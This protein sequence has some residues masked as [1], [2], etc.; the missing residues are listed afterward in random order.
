MYKYYFHRSLLTIALLIAPTLTHAGVQIN[1]IAWMGG[2]GNA[3]AEWIELFNTDGTDVSLAGWT[4]TSAGTAPNITLTGSI[5]AN[6]YYILERTSDASAPTVTADQIYTG[7]LSNSGDTLALKDQTG[8]QFDQV[9]GGSNWESIGGDNATKKTPQRNGGSWI[10]ADPT[11]RALNNTGTTVVG[12]T[13]TPTETTGTTTPVVTIGGTTPTT[14]TPAVSPVRTL[15][16]DAGNDRVVS[17]GVPTPFRAV[18]YSEG[19]N[20]RTRA[21]IAW[22]FGDGKRE[23]GDDVMYAY[24]YPGEYTVTVRVRDDLATALQTLRVV[25]ED[26]S[27]AIATDERGVTLSNTS[28][29]MIDLSGWEL[30]TIEDTFEIPEDTALHA[31]GAVLFASD[32]TELETDSAVALHYPNGVVAGSYEEKPQVVVREV[33]PEPV[34]VGIQEVATPTL[35]EPITEIPYEEVIDAPA[36]P[37]LTAS[38]GAAVGPVTVPVRLIMCLF[39]SLL[40]CGAS[41]VVP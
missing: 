18:A 36:E 35:P 24:R 30:R 22:N 23:E 28:P 4:I 5:L 1:E 19:G 2:V 8:T 7:A 37:I 40:A 20:V 25:V 13:T 16:V 10:T 3:N 33:Q 6:G 38:V 9:V 29:R 14:G 11:P 21:K 31:G 12:T 41:L 15:R 17:T 27:I 39:G 32:I 26:P 34:L